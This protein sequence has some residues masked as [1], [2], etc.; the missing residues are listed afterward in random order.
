MS[1]LERGH[2]VCINVANWQEPAPQ[3]RQLIDAGA[4][5]Y[6]RRRPMIGRSLRRLMHKMH[7]GR[8]RYAAWLRQSKPDF[9]LISVGYH[10]DDLLLAD[11]CRALNIPYG[12]LVQAASPYQWIEPHRFK[13]LQADYRQANRLFFVSEQNREIL[14][15]NLVLDLSHAEIVENPFKVRVAEPP[16]WPNSEQ[17]WKLACVARLHF[18]SKGQDLLLRLMCLPKLASPHPCKL[19]CGARTTATC[20]KSKSGSI[21]TGSIDKSAGV[22]LPIASN[23]CGLNTT[24][25]CF[26]RGSRAMPWP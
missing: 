26:H 24:A 22:A 25:C 1:L 16:P 7:V 6:W 2:D 4:Q 18:Q 8:H 3:I 21:S 15:A 5:P 12:V 10:T 13:Q 20:G 11:T 9:V 14:E 23:N 17:P 19:T